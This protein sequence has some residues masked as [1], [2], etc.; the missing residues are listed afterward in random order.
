ME[1]ESDSLSDLE[2]RAPPKLS[3]DELNQILRSTLFKELKTR[4]DILRSFFYYCKD[5]K[6]LRAYQR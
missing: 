2:L 5:S 1:A 6:N 3:F 4:K